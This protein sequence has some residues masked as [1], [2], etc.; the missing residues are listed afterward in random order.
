MD[1][2]ILY[3][4]A[5]YAA[6]GV[7]FLCC[8]AALVSR[9][10]ADRLIEV[11]TLDY[12]REQVARKAAERDTIEQKI[13]ELRAELATADR[14]KAELAIL[15]QEKEQRSLELAGIEEKLASLD[16]DRAKINEVEVA[17]VS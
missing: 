16:Q 10:A 8:W 7:V 15:R 3:S 2:A 17:P 1:V 4:P 9:N 12:L 13:S 6:A 11:P 5:T 14:E